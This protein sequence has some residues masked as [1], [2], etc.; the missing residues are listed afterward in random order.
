VLSRFVTPCEGTG[1]SIYDYYFYGGHSLFH[2]IQ[3]FSH[4]SR[5]VYDARS[6]T[7]SPVVNGDCSK[8][9][10]GAIVRAPMAE[11]KLTVAIGTK[12]DQIFGSIIAKRAPRTNMVYL[13]AV[14]GSTIL[15][16]PAIP[17]QYIVTKPSIRIRV[18]SKP[19]LSRA[20]RFHA[21]FS[22]CR[23][24]SIFSGPGSKE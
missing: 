20:N 12:S 15:A 23:R 21:V 22:T 13:K 1:F 24:N 16:S 2:E 3:L 6:R 9:R 14:R 10:K 18:E 4:S 7:R 19:V 11:M 8:F 17:H 5:H